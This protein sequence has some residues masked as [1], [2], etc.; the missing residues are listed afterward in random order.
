MKLY[1]NTIRLAVPAVMENL[2]N[3]AIFLVDALMVARLG[4]APLAAAG[5][6]GV[7]L[8]RLRSVGSCLQ[9]GTGATIA[10]RWGEGKTDAACD[11]F[12]HTLV[13]G[14]TLGLLAYLLLPFAHNLFSA[15]NAEG[16]VLR[17]IVPYF[18]IVL[19]GFPLRLASTNMAAA[20]RAAGDT[21]T[22]MTSTLAM[23]IVNVFFNYVFIF[24]HFGA[25][26]LGLVGAA[27]GT[28]ISFVFEFCFLL[29][30]GY[31]GIHPSTVFRKPP[32][33]IVNVADEVHAD[34][35]VYASK[36]EEP[37]T[38]ARF[39]FG[40]GGWKLS[41]PGVTRSIL[42][43][44][45]PT[46]WEEIAITAGFIGFFTMIASFGEA[47]IAAHT[48]I[49]RI[50]SF[51][52]NVGFG[53]SIAAATLV[54]QSLGA[55][56]PERARRTFGVCITLAVCSMGFVAILM[57]LF[58]EW[59]L[60]WFLPSHGR[61]FLDLAV[62]LMLIAAIEQPLLATTMVMANGLRG[63]GQTTAPFLAQMFGVLIIRI[64]VG[65]FLAF[66]MG[67]GMEGIYWA[68]L[69]DWTVRSAILAVL[70]L[71]SGWEKTHV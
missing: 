55:G 29:A 31:R 33:E 66:P 18:Q 7:I 4:S 27:I 71:R 49:V 54:G 13:L 69:I 63:A 5:M 58:P 64:G 53:I 10:R 62:P 70:V 50:E 26:A 38:R 48:A 12:S 20:M 68:T 67:L 36:R 16:E 61:G 44:S 60:G 17:L 32:I 15:M 23:N 45:H 51:S 41:I 34:H 21:R 11:I 52:F 2:F 46:F 57:S 8:W 1:K 35:D 9:F 3:S 24:G 37:A 59:F 47:A 40:R 28:L 19:L 65:W 30:V 6:A 22:P 25:P 14:F 56:S 43:I 39:H 42:R